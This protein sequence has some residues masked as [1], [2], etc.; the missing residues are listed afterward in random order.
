MMAIFTALHLQIN[1]RPTSLPV[2]VSLVEPHL[3]LVLLAFFCD[4]MTTL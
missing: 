1:S 2:A 4:Y 3:E